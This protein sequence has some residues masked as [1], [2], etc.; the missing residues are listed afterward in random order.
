M[1]IAGTSYHVQ[2]WPV[3]A[4]SP[5]IA[6]KKKANGYP[7]GRD[8]TAAQDIYT[9]RVRI[10][11]RTAVL[12]ALQATLD[13]NQNGI[14]LSGLSSGEMVFGANVD[15]SGS[16]AA[17]VTDFGTRANVMTNAIHELEIEFRAISPTL[18]ATT[19]SLASL[20][21]QEGWKG[22]RSTDITKTFAYNQTASYLKHLTDAG[23]FTGRFLQTTAQMQAIRAYLLTTARANPITFPALYPAPFNPFGANEADNRFQKCFAISWSDK[24]INLNRWE[25]QIDFAQARPYFSA[26]C[27]DTDNYSNAALMTPSSTPAFYATPGG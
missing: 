15:Y 5:A 6:W 25:L 8:R 21:L 16:I 27:L 7:T 17:T 24:R 23:T 10:A 11:D 19:P 1:I 26:G 3:P 22:D 13:A 20:K 14:T 9:G 2:L 18:L 12:D 4:T